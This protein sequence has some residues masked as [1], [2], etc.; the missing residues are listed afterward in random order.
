M[1]KC[2]TRSAVLVAA[3]AFCVAGCGA[4]ESYLVFRGETMGTT[5]TVKVTAQFDARTAKKIEEQCALLLENVNQEMSTYRPDSLL[6]RFNAQDST[7]PFRV[8]PSLTEVFKIALAVHEQTGGAFDITVGPLVNAWGFG[9][10]ARADPPP[11]KTIEALRERVGSGMLTVTE[12][13]I[14]KSRPDLYCDLSAVAKGY[15]VDVVAESLDAFDI[16]RYMVEVGGETRC[17]GTNPDGVPWRLGIEKPL[18]GVREIAKVV[19]LDN[20]AMATSGDYRN[21]YTA[22]GKRYAHTIDPRTGYPVDHMLASVTVLH[23][24]CA[25]ADAYATGIMVLGPEEGMAFAEEH[26]LPVFMLIREDDDTFT[27]RASSAWAKYMAS[28]AP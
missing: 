16:T 3:L 9:P 8:L 7:K 22:D 27:E 19:P 15:A 11:A 18:E 10:E 13:S 21:F 28:V 4:R 2:F 17:A 24:E 6:S 14:A 5:W 26:D 1:P 25:W 12:A 23:R 20:M